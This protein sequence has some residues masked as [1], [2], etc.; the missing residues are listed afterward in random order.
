[1]VDTIE[2][3]ASAA[4]DSLRPRQRRE[5]RPEDIAAVAALI[6]I[7]SVVACA[8]APSLIAPYL[9]TD[10]RSDAILSPP[11]RA[12]FFGTDQFGRDV[13]SLV[14][15]G[16]RPSLLIGVSA[17]VLGCSTG[18]SIG[19][20]AG[21]G[22]GWIDMGLMRFIDVWMAVPAILL[23]I[24]LSTALGP[25]P[26]T[27]IIAVS[28]AAIPR[29]ARV[30][31]GQAL[32][33]RSGAFVEAARSAGASHRAILL[34]HVLPHCAAPIII[35]AT[36]G[37]GGS[38]LVGSSLSFLGLG[39]ND[40]RPDWGYVLTQ[41]RGY[42][43]VAWWTVTYPGL[44]ITALV[45]SVNLVGDALRRRLD[46][47]QSRSR[48]LETAGLA[49]SLPLQSATWLPVGGSE[50]AGESPEDQKTRI[51]LRV[52]HLSIRFGGK[53]PF[54][55]VEDVTFTVA[56]GETVCLVGESGSGKTIT[57]LSILRLEALR[58]ASIVSGNVVFDGIRLAALPAARL[59]ALR[60]RRVA[61][62]FQEPMTAFDPIFTIGDQI[63]ETIRR[64]EPIGRAAAWE[65]G[66]RLLERVHISD[67]RLRME[68]IP[69]ELSGGMRQR[70]MIAMAL[71][72]G[73]DLL[74]ADEPTTALDVTI[75]AQILA[76]LKELQRESG[77]AILLITHDL[78]VAAEMADRVV[79]MY[80]GRVAEQGPVDDLFVRPQ[81]PYTR[82]L[83]RAAVPHGAKAA[84]ALPAIAGSIPRLDDVP[85]GCRF[86]PRCQLASARC[87]EES[88]PTD[89]FGQREIACW[90]ASEND[91]D[92]AVVAQGSRVETAGELPGAPLL[93]GVR[94]S[95]YFEARRSWFAAR[96]R[97]CALDDV[98]L[99]I[100]KGETFGLVGESGCGK[101]TLGR[102][103]LQLETPSSGQVRFDGQT[104]ADLRGRERKRARRDMQMIFQ[105]PSGSI[106]P[107]WTVHDV[108]AEPLVSHERWTRQ[109]LRARVD[110]LLD[111]VGLDPS[112]RAHYAHEFSGGQRQRIGIARAIA[113]R[114]RF[115]V[116]DEAVSALDLSVQAQIINLLA[117]LRERLGLTSLFIGH[118]LNVVR[119]LSDRIGVMYLGRMVEVAPADDLFERPVHHYSHALLTS[120]PSPDPRRRRELIAPVGELPSPTAPPSGCHFHPRCPAATERCRREVPALAPIAP[121]RLVACHHP[122]A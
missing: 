110:E 98:S 48:A 107:R 80:A 90:H 16:A 117:D 65:R 66:V 61:M 94:L 30:L 114:P 32:A 106:D 15:Y 29:Y 53:R 8:V 68:Q 121:N 20:L 51:L 5:V 36:L 13:F 1:M 28:I 122:R 7:A 77:M 67:A 58:G 35:M 62:I 3:S 87:A 113:L 57:A 69:E 74:I 81:H 54:D 91:P 108:I 82:G 22:G 4:A 95:K 41:G 26:V 44:A 88:P 11:S 64:H 93:E 52:E 10:M 18:V 55:V 103:L 102:V 116:A 101:S 118:G 70:A 72:C 109:A 115:I 78:G 83:L 25:S 27:V 100:R 23:A 17:V 84:G 50:H 120:I 47:R 76:L 112:A 111:L 119:H 6:V 9:P 40:E 99:T 46:P 24:S 31:R 45:V 75:Q 63:V 42:L 96:K 60:G 14:V 34:R 105:D 79:V 104:V 19:L 89:T 33:V 39:V 49:K 59:D 85:P 97:V 92:S 71:A 2:A 21:Y 56:R 43:T 37:V 38:I 73:P 86:H 12:H